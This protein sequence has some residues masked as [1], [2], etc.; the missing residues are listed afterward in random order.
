MIF[1]KPTLRTQASF[2]AGIAELGGY[3]MLV[4]GRLAGIGDRESIADVARVLGRQAR[5][6]CG[7]PTSRPD[8]GDGRVRRRA[9][10]QCA[11]RRVPPLPAARRP[12]DRAGA[13]GR[14]GRAQGRVRRRRRLQ[15]GQLVGT[16]RRDRGDAGAVRLARRLRAGRGDGR[17]GGGDRRDDRRLGR[18]DDPIAAVADADVVVTDT[19]VSMGK[20]EEA[21]ARRAIFAPYSVTPSSSPTRSPTRS[22][23]TACRPTG[24]PRSPP[25]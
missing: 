14:P 3:P 5:R 24:A 12:A 11:H 15:H 19:W 13:Q 9:R 20:E 22:C 6:S 25:R 17:A 10:D 21:E 7:A 16:G 8:R 1:D 4:E 2:A 23:C 18:P